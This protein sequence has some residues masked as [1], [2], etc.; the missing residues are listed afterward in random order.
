MMLPE[1]A[2]QA[3]CNLQ[4]AKG[5]TAKRGTG[6]MRWASSCLLDTRW[7]RKQDYCWDCIMKLAI[8]HL[9]G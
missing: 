6:R 9:H 8:K 4:F 1:G 7:I 3:A 5:L 2:D